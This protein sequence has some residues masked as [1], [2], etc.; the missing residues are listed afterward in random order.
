[1]KLLIAK[2]IA[3]SP[4]GAIT[5]RSR[6]VDQR[7]AHEEGGPLLPSL[8]SPLL[9]FAFADSDR[10]QRRESSR[11][12]LDRQPVFNG[13]LAPV[14]P[15]RIEH[16]SDAARHSRTVEAPGE[17]SAPSGDPEGRNIDMVR[18]RAT[19]KPSRTSFETARN[20]ALARL[21]EGL[22]LRWTP[23]TSRGELHRLPSVRH[24][25]Q[26]PHSSR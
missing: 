24:G 23:P 18:K 15:R 21:R 25:N 7:T 6:L 1:M 5:F 9:F 22:D 8:C 17:A 14:E 13:L 16:E 2:N 19:P 10:V 20:R 4:T 11:P 26:N 12:K 3:A